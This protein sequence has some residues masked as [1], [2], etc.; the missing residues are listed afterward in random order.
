VNLPQNRIKM[1]ISLLAWLIK[2]LSNKGLCGSLLNPPSNSGIV[3]LFLIPK[4]KEP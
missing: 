3:V 1:A 2:L 4:E